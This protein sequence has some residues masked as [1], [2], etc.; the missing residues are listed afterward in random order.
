M[1]HGVIFLLLML[2]FPITTTLS[3]CQHLLVSVTRLALLPTRLHRS[4]DWLHPQTCMRCFADQAHKALSS[5][6][7]PALSVLVLVGSTLSVC[8]HAFCDLVECATSSGLELLS[9]PPVSREHP[10]EKSPAPHNHRSAVGSNLPLPESSPYWVY[11][12]AG[13][14]LLAV[15]LA[16][17]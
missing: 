9:S 16:P 13:P 5:P 6:F 15:I 4:L 7:F 1:L 10:P 3:K 14:P 2:P 12:A 11:P 8:K 17:G